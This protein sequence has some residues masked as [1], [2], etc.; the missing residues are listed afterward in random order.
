[1]DIHL[2]YKVARSAGGTEE[3]SPVNPYKVNRPAGSGPL[4]VM[5][6]RSNASICRA[7]S[8]SRTLSAFH[9]TTLQPLLAQW[10]YEDS[11]DWTAETH[12]F[13]NKPWL[14]LYVCSSSDV[15]LLNPANI[16]GNGWNTA[17]AGSAAFVAIRDEVSVGAETHV[18]MVA[19]G[20]PDWG[21]KL[22]SNVMDIKDV[23][24]VSATG[25]AYA[26]RRRNGQV[27][28]W[29]NPAEGGSLPPGE[30]DDFVQVRAGWHVFIGRKNDGR[31]VGWG[32]AKL[33]ANIPEAVSQH[34]DYVELCGGGGAFAARRATGQIVAWGEPDLGGI[35][36]AG[37]DSLNDI[38]QLSAS[39]AAFAALREAG[40]VRSVIGWGHEGYGGHV[41]P[42]IAALANVRALGAATLS[43][44]AILLDTGEVRGWGDVDY[45]GQVPTLIQS[46]T[47]VV[48][49]S[50]TWYAFCARLS[51]GHVVAWG[52]PG[53]GGL[54]PEAIEQLSDVVQVVGS[55]RSFAALRR[56]GTVVAWGDPNFGGDTSQVAAEL[57]N[58]RAVYSNTNAFTALTSDG[59][60]VTWGDAAGGGDS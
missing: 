50:S 17:A 48:E 19:W 56:D 18:D 47:N 32:I 51:D 29:G 22:D 35:L 11:E 37:Q 55:A 16:I 28:C 31:L 15:V 60:V 52:N 9:N 20:I 25:C 4:R 38:I 14:K 2:K 5:G 7:S 46:L 57:V 8:A 36:G 23:V 59:R 13:D 27:V 1:E 49:V 43:A 58:V 6:A 33:G 24:E 54:V 34:R 12:W 44:F 41:P 10:R 40:G 21:G 26:A 53:T 39:H 30:E 45:G 42:A 3:E